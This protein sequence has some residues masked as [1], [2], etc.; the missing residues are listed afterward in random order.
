MQFSGIEHLDIKNTSTRK[1]LREMIM[2]LK[3]SHFINVDLN[4]K[5]DSYQI[6]F[7]KKY[8]T[9]ARGIIAHL[10]AYLHKTY[11]DAILTSLPAETQKLVSAT[12][13]DDEGNPVSVVDKELDDI[14]AED[15]DLDFVDISFL[16][17]EN[18]NEKRIPV[19]PEISSKFIPKLDTD[20]VSTFKTYQPNMEISP[21]KSELT[22][23]SSDNHTTVSA[24]TLDSRM[25]NMEHEVHKISTL[26]QQIANR[27]VNEA[28]VAI[29]VCGSEGKPA[30]K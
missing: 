14:L 6:I 9:T 25:S 26:L 10:A 21:D 19:T 22:D 15:D 12:A 2:G 3:D 18:Q 11:G 20:S 4:W 23:R 5:Q 29:P 30:A 7:P 16:Q 8:D 28:G 17:T 1:T 27:K 13:W 24:I